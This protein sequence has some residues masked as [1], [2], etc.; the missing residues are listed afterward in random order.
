MSQLHSD[1]AQNVHGDVIKELCK[2]VGTVKS[3]SS[4]L[5][6]QGDGMAE[7]M[8]KI[9]KNSARKQVDKFGKD[10]DSYLQPT[11]FAVR[12]NINSGTKHTPAELVLGDNMIRPIDLSVKNDKPST[13]AKK[14]AREFSVQ[15]KK[16]IEDASAVVNENLQ[17][18][19]ER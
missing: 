15:L 19:E 12:S 13:F 10:W 1:G 17:K 2:L 8:V 16:K 9:L 5:H 14:Q 11:A 18:R 3:K 6:P 4:R 7:S